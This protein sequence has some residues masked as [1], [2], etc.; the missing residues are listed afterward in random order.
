MRQFNDPACDRVGIEPA[1]MHQGLTLAQRRVETRI[2]ER[3]AAR[4][5]GAREITLNR[6]K[7]K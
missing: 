2:T 5:A 3:N 1:A 6:G 7:F 4:D